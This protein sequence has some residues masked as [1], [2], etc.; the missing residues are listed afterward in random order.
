MKEMK[1][2][3]L[4]PPMWPPDSFTYEQ[5]T[6]ALMK[7]EAEDEARQEAKRNRVRGSKRPTQDQAEAV[8][9]NDR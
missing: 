3:E 1:V 6:A 7:A 9:G 5:A 4:I 8:G 2:R